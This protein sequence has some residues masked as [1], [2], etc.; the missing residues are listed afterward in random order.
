MSNWGRKRCSCEKPE[1]FR[2]S[3][4]KKREIEKDN[5]SKSHFGFLAKISRLS[6]DL[7]I[8]SEFHNLVDLFLEY[9]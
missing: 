5:V 2:F 6:R 9:F 3:W 4:V 7:I 1:L 8:Q